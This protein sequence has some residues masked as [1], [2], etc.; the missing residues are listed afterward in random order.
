VQNKRSEKKGLSFREQ[1]EFETIEATIETMQQHLANLEASFA[2][3]RPT[4][5]GT[6]AERTERYHALRNELENLEER[7]LELAQKS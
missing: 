5:E 4:Q 3:A 7:W 6:L 1:K 2:D